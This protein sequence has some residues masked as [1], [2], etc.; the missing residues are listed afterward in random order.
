MH[1]LYRRS[2]T[3]TT[4]SQQIWFHRPLK[5]CP[6]P[7]SQIRGRS[8]TLLLP[9]LISGSLTFCAGEFL[10]PS[11]GTSDIEGEDKLKRSEPPIPGNEIL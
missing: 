6:I 9:N 10:E 4:T 8:H 11:H 7:P 3:L 5:L 1:T 2:P